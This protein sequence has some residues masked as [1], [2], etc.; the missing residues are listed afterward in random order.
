VA[1]WHRD[2]GD[3]AQA[4]A[5]LEASRLALTPAGLMELARYRL[6]SRDWTGARDLWEPLAEAGDQDA[7]AALSRLWEHRLGDPAQALALARR[8]PPSP[9]RERRCGRLER[10][11]AR[12]RGLAGSDRTVQA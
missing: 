9:E 4:R 11:V 1:V 3:Q 5:I 2:R 12:H 10:L 8:L 6:R 7:V